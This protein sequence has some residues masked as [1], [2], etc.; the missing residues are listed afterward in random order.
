[1]KNV[2]LSIILPV[3]NVEQYIDNCLNSILKQDCEGIEIILVDD[4]TPDNAGKICDEYKKK[5]DF[6]KVLHKANKGSY[7]ARADGIKLAEG[8]YLWFVDSDDWLMDNSISKMKGLIRESNNSDMLIFGFC[9]NGDLDTAVASPLS[10]GQYK[11]SD[12]DVIKDKLIR[13]STINSVWRKCIRRE[14]AVGNSEIIDISNYSYGEDAYLSCC[15]IDK[16]DSVYVSNDVLYAYRD[17]FSSM[18]HT[19]NAARFQQE[20]ITIGKLEHFSV[21]WD[22]DNQLKL[23][24]SISNRIIEE[25]LGDLRILLESGIE[26]NKEN[27]LI[28]ELLKDDYFLNALKENNTGFDSWWENWFYR[29]LKKNPNDRSFIN[30]YKRIVGLKRLFKKSKKL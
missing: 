26:K 28:N 20:K 8:E 13:S 7:Q 5:Y 12:I 16:A 25:W 21:K 3:Y 11:N 6:I 1:M 24:D 19:Y 17:N 29:V 4:G 14:L 2:W 9:Y 18:T 27:Q 23:K 22:V 30:R 10:I 15:F